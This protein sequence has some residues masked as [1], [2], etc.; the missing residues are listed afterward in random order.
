MFV[1]GFVTCSYDESSTVAIVEAANMLS[2]INAYRLSTPLYADTAYPVVEAT[3]IELEADGKI[4]SRDA[5]AWYVQDISKHAH[6]SEV[7]ETWWNMRS[8]ILTLLA[9]VRHS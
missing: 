2:G 9:F 6:Y 1:R 3:Q 4:R 8:C 5:L 7:V